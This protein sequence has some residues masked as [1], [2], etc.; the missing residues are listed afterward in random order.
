[1]RGD[2][3]ASPVAPVRARRAGTADATRYA[4]GFFWHAALP[5]LYLNAPPLI[6]K[7][8]VEHRDGAAVDDV[9]VFYEEP[10]IGDGEQRIRADFYQV[11][12]HDAHDRYLE[13]TDLLDPGWTGAA[14]SV[15]SRFGERWRALRENEP[16][17]RLSLVTN[18]PWNPDDLLA[19]LLRDRGMLD[20]PFFTRGTTSTLGKTGREWR[21]QLGMPDDETFFEFVQQLRLWPSPVSLW[22]AENRLSKRCALAGLKA[23]D[24]EGSLNPYDE[25]AGRLLADGRRE[26]T[27]A[28]LSR[29]LQQE[30]LVAAAA[31]PF[32]STCAI[33]SVRALASV[34]EMEA[35]LTVDLS[36]LLMD[37]EPIDPAAWSR[38]VPGRLRAAAAEFHALPRPQR[39]VLDTHLSIGWLA[40]TILGAEDGLILR[41]TGRGDARAEPDPGWLLSVERVGAGNE[42]ALAISTTR[43]IAA[44]VR[45]ALESLVPA[46]GS[47]LDARLPA[48][49]EEAIRSSLHARALADKITSVLRTLSPAREI[50]R[51]HVFAACPVD[52]AFLV[53]QRSAGLGPMTF[54][55]I[56]PRGSRAYFPALSIP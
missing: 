17:V 7:V 28:Q 6:E 5:M 30:G 11:M 29:I 26:F 49:G 55:E 51:T 22:A 24:F 33:R 35:R 8:V 53:G 1:M 4:Y 32:Q 42:M 9:T 43:D 2:T 19:P 16:R 15:V 47:L 31:P 41:E 38:E 50:A 34:P 20:D 12:F 18:I 44:E 14:Q 52:L 10:G 37:G 13:C 27:P 54:Y 40:G 36:D 56:D 3:A 39:L 23:P 48:L 46:A 21:E 45:R 25:L